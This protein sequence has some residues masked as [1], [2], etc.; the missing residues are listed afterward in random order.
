MFT[1]SSEPGT[2]SSR[3]QGIRWVGLSELHRGGTPIQNS[4]INAKAGSYTPRFGIRV[5]IPGVDLVGPVVEASDQD[6][7]PMESGQRFS[8]DSARQW[9]SPLPSG[10]LSSFSCWK[11]VVYAPKVLHHREELRDEKNTWQSLVGNSQG[12]AS[13][14]RCARALS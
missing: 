5:H 12:T 13:R 10:L 3:R 7:I 11:R 8:L 4:A 14:G 2:Y 1:K 6:G 9:T